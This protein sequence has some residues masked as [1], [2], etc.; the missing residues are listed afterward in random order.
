MNEHKP[1]LKFY[2]EGIPHDINPDAYESVIDLMEAGFEKH[3]SKAA[4]SNMGKEMTFAQIDEQSKNFAAYLQFKGL[5]PGD[6]IA[7]QM[8]NCLQYPI[9]LFGAIR[10][11]LVVVNTN[12]LYTPR[13]MT[14]QFKDSGAKAIVIVANFAFNLEKVLPNTQIEHVFVT[15]LGDMLGFPKKHIV[16]FV[17]KTVKKMVPSYSLPSA[18]SLSDALSK[19]GAMTYAKPKVKNTE[20]AFIQYTGG[21]TGVSKGAMLTHRNVVANLEA[22]DAWQS[23]LTKDIKDDK[24]VVVAALPLYH[25]YALTVNALTG[26]KTGGMNLLITNP[27]DMDSFI[28]DLKKNPPHLFTGLNTLYNGLLNHPKFGEVDFS[29][30]VITS[31]GGMALQKVV[32]QRWKDMTGCLPA[33][34]YGLSET[35]PV[36]SSNPLVGDNRIGTIGIP[37]PSTEMKILKDDGTWAEVG[38]VGEICAHGPQVF[39]GYYNRQDETDKVMLIDPIDGRQWFKTGDVGVMDAD[40]YFKIVDRKKD[41][42]LVSGFNVY[43]NEVEDVIAQC[44]GVL[45][46]ACIGVPNDRSTEAVKVFIVKKDPS[47][48]EAAVKA[49]AREQLTPY[50]CPKHV[51]FRDELPKTNV[52]KILRR[53]LK[54]EEAKSKA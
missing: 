21:T 1:W 45:E 19:G 48:T 36:L 41:M 6:R 39:S 32:A 27:R 50:K 25:V 29:K 37:W 17:V 46:V 7:I 53:A 51:E 20:L 30:L 33:E 44:P 12:P 26:L 34:G 52:G 9:V 28:K 42:I 11:G 15:E 47:L 4:Y 13:E 40:G 43:P 35:S 5:L 22:N 3:A 38:E 23:V 31:A 2:P 24:I 54:D 10:A 8:P 16:N 49:F 14:H 18:E